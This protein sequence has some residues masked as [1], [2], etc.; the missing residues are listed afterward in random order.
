M[1]YL[2]KNIRYPDSLEQNHNDWK[3]VV[4]FIVRKDGTL[5]DVKVLKSAGKLLDDEVVRLVKQMPPWIPGKD[6]GVP[7]NVYFVLPVVFEPE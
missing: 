6:H 1:A 7:V 3:V 4:Q 5:T 2:A